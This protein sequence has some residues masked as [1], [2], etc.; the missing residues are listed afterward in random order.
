MKNNIFADYILSLPEKVSTLQSQAA[1]LLEEATSMAG[2]LS[3]LDLAKIDA[4]TLT[5]NPKLDAALRLSMESGK[6][7]RDWLDVFPRILAKISH[8]EKQIADWQQ[9]GLMLVDLTA[10]DRCP[11]CL[12]FVLMEVPAN[13]AIHISASSG[14]FHDIPISIRV[15]GRLIIAWSSTTWI[16]GLDRCISPQPVEFRISHGRRRIESDG[17]V[18]QEST[19]DLTLLLHPN[20]GT[21]NVRLAGISLGISAIKKHIQD[22]SEFVDEGYCM[23]TLETKN[24]QQFLTDFQSAMETLKN[25]NA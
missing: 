5:G 1:Q 9:G 22:W 14:Y 11:I 18:S 24:Y 19:F 20:W 17:Q 6:R 25:V 8:F 4:L 15:P 23:S 13:P 3:A 2:F 7:G 21:R 10:Q 12:N 16:T